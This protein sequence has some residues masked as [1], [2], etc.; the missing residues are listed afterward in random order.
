MF[1]SRWT[2]LKDYNKH[3]FTAPILVYVCHAKT[4]YLFLFLSCAQVFINILCDIYDDDKDTWLNIKYNNI[5]TSL[6]V[7][8]THRKST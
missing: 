5:Q 7:N 8:F 4:C 3:G 1:T 2:I 6:N